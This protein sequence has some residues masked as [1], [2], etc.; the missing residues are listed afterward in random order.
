MRQSQTEQGGREGCSRQ[1]EEPGSESLVG[2]RT[3]RS[4]AQ[5]IVNTRASRGDGAG[6]VPGGFF[7]EP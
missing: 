5:N 7:E 2:E 3:V 4:L 1:R 6:K